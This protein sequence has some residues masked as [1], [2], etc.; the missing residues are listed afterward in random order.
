MRFRVP[1]VIQLIFKRRTWRGED[2]KTVYLTFDDGPDVETTPGVLSLL[3]Q[4]NISATF[5]CLGKNIEAHPNLYHKII[6][7]GHCI[8]NHTYGHEKGTKTQTASYLKSILQTEQLHTSKLFRPPYGRI[9]FIQVSRILRLGKKII[10]W[11]WNSQDYNPKMEPKK[12]IKNA[13]KI[14]GKDILLFHNSQKSKVLMEQSLKSVIDIVKKKGLT[15]S[16][17]E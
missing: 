2:P 6:E 3:A 8:G 12:I 15:F 17:L 11:T 9:R 14:K 10:M 4:E 7:E 1:F 16:T 5:F 13:K